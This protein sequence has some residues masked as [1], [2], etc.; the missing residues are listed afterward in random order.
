M[1]EV[2][3]PSGK[4]SVK[5]YKDICF[6]LGYYPQGQLT[7]DL[8]GYSIRGLQQMMKRKKIPVIVARFLRLLE[9]QHD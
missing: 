7:A 8:L 3:I 4:M 9:N 2:K 6:K 5:Q 1:Q